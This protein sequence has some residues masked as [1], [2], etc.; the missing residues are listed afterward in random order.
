MATKS[1]VN[2]MDRSLRLLPLFL[3]LPALGFLLPHGLITHSFLPAVGIVPL[4]I[5]A[6][7]SVVF[8]AQKRGNETRRCDF[9]VLLDFILAVSHIAVLIPTWILVSEQNCGWRRTYQY[10]RCTP[11]L[12]MLGTYGTMFLMI[13]L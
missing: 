7:S 5:S 2:T 4:A 10:H 6:V 8:L 13:N 3:C 9:G 12:V 1:N 11:R